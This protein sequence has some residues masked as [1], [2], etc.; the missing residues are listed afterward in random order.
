MLDF[1]VAAHNAVKTSF[2]QSSIKGCFF[3]YIQCIWRKVQSSGLVVMFNEDDNFRRLV[4]RAAVLP[5]VPE[6]KDGWFQALEDNQDDSPPVMRFK[7]YVTETWVGG[8]LQH[9]NHYDN[10]GP[11]TTNAAEG[12]HQ[13]LI[14]MCR[15]PHQISTSSF[16]HFKKNALRMR[17]RLFNWMWGDCETKKRKYRQLDQRIQLLKDRVRQNANGV[18]EY[19]DVASHLLHLQ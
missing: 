12:W 13:K 10:D 17:R 5:L 9:W 15:R 18:M 7:N 1:E 4:K 19:A 16:K 8:H 2:P 14:A 3:H 6:N 11:R